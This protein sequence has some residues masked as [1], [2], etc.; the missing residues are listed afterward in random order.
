[1]HSLPQGRIGVP[2]VHDDSHIFNDVHL[3][4]QSGHGNPLGSLQGLLYI[5]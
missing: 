4:N 2:Y 3:V 5:L 1:M